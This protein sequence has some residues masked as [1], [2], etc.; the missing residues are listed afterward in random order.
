MM[1]LVTVLHFAS[2]I[3]MFG[4][5]TCIALSMWPAPPKATLEKK[6][7]VHHNAQLARL[8]LIFFAALYLATMFG[9][10]FVS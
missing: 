8:G 5:W 6:I 1:T 4:L 7:A 10:E 9:K 3:S 2:I